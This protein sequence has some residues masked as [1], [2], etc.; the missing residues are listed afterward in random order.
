MRVSPTEE[1]EVANDH[2]ADGGKQLS[3]VNPPGTGSDRVD[4]CGR[5]LSKQKNK[6]LNCKKSKFARERSNS[7]FRPSLSSALK[8]LYASERIHHRFDVEQT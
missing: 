1:T 3:G 8:R 4:V 7:R 2:G 6:T 5:T